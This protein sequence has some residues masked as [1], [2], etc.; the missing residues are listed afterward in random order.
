VFVIVCKVQDFRLWETVSRSQTRI[1][2]I[3]SA[4][5]ESLIAWCLRRRDP[6]AIASGWQLGEEWEWFGFAL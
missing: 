4:S 1:D 6:S 3:L 5:E 2:V